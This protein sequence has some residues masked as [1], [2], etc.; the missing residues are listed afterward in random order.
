MWR[1]SITQIG[2]KVMPV[3]RT[4]WMPHGVVV[5]GELE[6]GSS[7]H[8]LWVWCGAAGFPKTVAEGFCAAVGGLEGR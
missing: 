2:Q 7:G 3:G 1:M 5:D 8:N 4:A 6:L